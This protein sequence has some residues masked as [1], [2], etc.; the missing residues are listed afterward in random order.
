MIKIEVMLAFASAFTPVVLFY[1]SVDV[2]TMMSYAVSL[3]LACVP[4]L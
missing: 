2:I 3:M 1:F 4:R